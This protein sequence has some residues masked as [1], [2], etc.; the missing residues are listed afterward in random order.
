M[1]HVE[2]THEFYEDEVRCDF[3]VPELI[4]RTWAAQ[5]QVLAD[6]DKLCRE[7][8]IEYFA[9]WGTLLGTVRHA[10]FIP[11]DDD[12]DVC[13]KR[14]DYNRFLQVASRL[15][16]NYSIVSF[17]SSDNFKHMLCR[18][19]NT[20][21]Y[22]FDREFLANYSGLPFAVGIDIFPMDFLSDNQQFED[23]R[24]QKVYLL[25]SVIDKLA[26]G[27][28]SQKE[29]TSD[30]AMV[31]SLLGISVNTKGNILL[32]LRLAMEELYG[33]VSEKDA[34]EITLY[35]IWFSNH[36]YRFPKEWYA[37]SVRLPFEN[38]DIPVPA[39]F[40]PILSKKYGQSYLTPIRSGGAH[41]YPYCQN[42]L[43]VLRE[44]FDF[45]WPSYKYCKDDWT[46]SRNTKF[47]A[48]D[49]VNGYIATLCNLSESIRTMI[50]ASALDDA[51][52]E[53]LT[54]CQNTAVEL[55]TFIEQ[56]YYESS[57][58]V[59]LL[60][61]YCETIFAL[62]EQPNIELLNQSDMLLERIKSSFDD[63]FAGRRVILFISHSALAFTQCVSLLKQ[64]IDVPNTIVKFMPIPRYEH[65][66]SMDG[67]NV[68]YNP[69]EYADC[70]ITDRVHFT[71]YSQFD[72]E[73]HPDVIVSD[74]PYDGFN[75]ITGIDKKYYS[76]SLK[77]CCDKLIYVQP[78]AVNSIREDDERA[79]LN[80]RSY[81]NTPM[82]ARADEVYVTSEE[83]RERYI[84]VL[85][86]FTNHEFDAL[87]G[88]KIK[89]LKNKPRASEQSFP[90]R[91]L[92]HVEVSGFVTQG[93]Q[94]VEKIRNVLEVFASS[95]DKVIVV[96]NDAPKLVDFL[97][98]YDDAI[99]K[100]YIDL[101]R[102]YSDAGNIEWV[103]DTYLNITGSTE[104]TEQN[105]GTYETLAAKCDAYYGDAS[106][107]VPIFSRLKK[108]VMIAN[109]EII[110]SS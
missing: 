57:R 49:K 58:T 8:N 76:D 96:Y 32:Q 103:S 75:L 74:W 69:D 21:H 39:G 108:P 31:Q 110:S 1:N 17:R 82:V 34:T 59:G 94:M 64:Y 105:K 77:S 20:D 29:L 46:Y 92:F 73:V 70:A 67:S 53:L 88:N 3:L 26:D 13:M 16:D 60:E 101:I 61:E 99:G 38:I 44:H 107:Y 50:S 84:E 106:P 78:F 52:I 45:E 65:A 89:V 100:A 81:V 12:L 35:P 14:K 18:I 66:A 28:I 87:I 47:N 11:W 91:I 55:G 63:D 25:Q 4:K 79:I 51:Y 56:R 36:D 37:H 24:F 43:N 83:V 7:N 97:K 71:D 62:S 10:G 41:D 40:I 86:E 9:E 104:V 23:E 98:S 102:E 72:L 30:L 33:A 68:V 6:L 85:G 90:K 54:V 19:V 22:R 27:H 2:F 48:E 42:H 93:M 80:M 5:I 95:E 109:P 15:P